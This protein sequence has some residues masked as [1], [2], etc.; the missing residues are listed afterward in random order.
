MVKH[1]DYLWRQICSGLE[2]EEKLEI[3]S[4]SLQNEIYDR[5]KGNAVNPQWLYWKKRNEFQKL[6]VE[7]G[8]QLVSDYREA[9][10]G[11]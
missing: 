3:E 8:N 6:M 5:R 7:A 1:F 10:V 2:T 4:R 9:N 11:K